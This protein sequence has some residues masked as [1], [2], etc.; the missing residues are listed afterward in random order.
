[1]TTKRK[2]DGRTK[3]RSSG[4]LVCFPIESIPNS[5]A[6]RTG[7]ARQEW[8][9]CTHRMVRRK[10]LNAA[11]LWLATFAHRL[12][13]NTYTRWLAGWRLNHL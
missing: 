1:M 3:Q 13:T 5:H 2:N 7:L 11:Y 4:G 12:V 8:N 10:P 9:T 6:A